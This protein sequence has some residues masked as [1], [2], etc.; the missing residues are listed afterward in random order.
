M[1]RQYLMVY[2]Y[3]QGISNDKLINQLNKDFQD[4]SDSQTMNMM[5]H[6]EK[7]ENTNNGTD[8]FDV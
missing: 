2:N 7:C 8:Q 5:A 4:T 1:I 3:G 6:I